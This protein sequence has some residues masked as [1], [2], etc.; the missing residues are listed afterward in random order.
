MDSGSDP[1]GEDRAKRR[2]RAGFFPAPRRRENPAV[3]GMALAAR[4]VAHSGRDD[5]ITYY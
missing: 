1:R 2:R 3:L 4:D 5:D